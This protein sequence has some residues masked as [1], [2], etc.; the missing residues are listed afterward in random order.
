MLFAFF[1]EAYKNYFFSLELFCLVKE[2]KFKYF[3]I[4]SSFGDF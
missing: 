1:C 3:K 4:W 2:N